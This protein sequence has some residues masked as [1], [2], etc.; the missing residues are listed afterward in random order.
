MVKVIEFIERTESGENLYVWVRNQLVFL[1][2]RAHTCVSECVCVCVC[3][4]VYVCVMLGSELVSFA[5]EKNATTSRV[6]D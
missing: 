6:F 4:C 1:S 5:Q 2:V 3:A